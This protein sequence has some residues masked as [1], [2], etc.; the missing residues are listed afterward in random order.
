MNINEVSKHIGVSP[1]TVS[2][3]MNNYDN[4][5]PKTREKVMAGVRELGYITNLPGRNLRAVST[6]IFL[7]CV[8]SIDN[9]FYAEIVRS[10]EHEAIKHDYNIM[11]CESYLSLKRYRFFADSVKA[12]RADGII[13]LS[14][15]S[16]AIEYFN[17]VPFVICGETAGSYTCDTVDI[18]NENAGCEAVKHLIGAGARKIMCMGGNYKSGV[19]RIQGYKKALSGAGISFNSKLLFD[20]L[21]S[22]YEEGYNTVTALLD[23]GESFDG[24]FAC[25]DILATGAVNA[26]IAAGKKVPDDVK[27]VGFDDL[28]FSKMCAV[29]ITTIRQPRKEMG[30][31]SFNLLYEKVKNKAENRRQ[32]I[33]NHELIVRKSTL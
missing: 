8:Q 10:I 22:D 11:I 4:V 32:I 23:S 27:V 33:I 1:A 19:Q 28:I 25:T 18:D 26:L 21:F 12:K 24:I 29:P 3:V 17:D 15:S 2:R 6:K 9:P 14:P 30:E 20:N 7:I 13:L 5:D 16:E 31:A